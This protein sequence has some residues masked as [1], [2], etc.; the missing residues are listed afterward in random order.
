M[1]M[2]RKSRREKGEEVEEEGRRKATVYKKKENIKTK[3]GEKRE[4]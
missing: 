4:E 2:G 1:C 3:E